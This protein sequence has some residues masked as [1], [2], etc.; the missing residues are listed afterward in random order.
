MSSVKRIFH[1][2]RTQRE[3]AFMRDAT[4][5]ARRAARSGDCSGFEIGPRTHSGITL[6]LRVSYKLENPTGISLWLG[7]GKVSELINLL[8]NITVDISNFRQE[9]ELSARYKIAARV[10][11]ILVL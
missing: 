6:R 5:F 3:S 9:F 1:R 4:H 8:E 11:N 7:R 10:I 2:L